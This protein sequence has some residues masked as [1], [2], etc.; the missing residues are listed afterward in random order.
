MCASY[1]RVRR[2]ATC[3]PTRTDIFPTRVSS[4]PKACGRM[5]LVGRDRWA[6]R[7]VL[8]PDLRPLYPNRSTG[9]AVRPCRVITV[10]CWLLIILGV[11]CFNPPALFED[12]IAQGLQMIA[13]NLPNRCLEMLDVLAEFQLVG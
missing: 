6:R 5:R 1:P 11:S 9:P 2:L 7:N 13:E 10:H 3:N 8:K 12:V 4:G